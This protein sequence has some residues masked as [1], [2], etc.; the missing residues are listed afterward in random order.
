MY[1]KI[2]RISIVFQIDFGEFCYMDII[3]L[4]RACLVNSQNYAPRC[5]GQLNAL[6]SEATRHR[7]I[8]H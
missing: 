1:V 6:L 3:L 4:F 2:L 7:A 8:V 5:R